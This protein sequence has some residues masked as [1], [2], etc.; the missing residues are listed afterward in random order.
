M[1]KAIYDCTKHQFCCPECDSPAAGDF[2]PK[3]LSDFAKVIY[4]CSNIDCN[5]TETNGT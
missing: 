2:E 1:N 3:L 4:H 5:W